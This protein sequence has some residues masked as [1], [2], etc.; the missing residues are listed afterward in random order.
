MSEALNSMSHQLFCKSAG[1]PAPH[2]LCNS[3]HFCFKL[4]STSATASSTLSLVA[5]VI[6]NDD[7]QPYFR[8]ISNSS[9]Y[10]YLYSPVYLFDSQHCLRQRACP[11]ILLFF[12][13]HN[14]G[15]LLV[16]TLPFPLH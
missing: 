16:A 11:L 14:D 1:I 4:S 15:Q 3:F 10:F 2:A 6:T 8:H 5:V 7:G 13:A 12:I 9:I